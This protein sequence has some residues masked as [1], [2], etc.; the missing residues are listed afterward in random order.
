M[1]AEFDFFDGQFTGEQLDDAVSKR[2]DHANRE[3]L[4]KLGISA[5]GDLTVDG[6]AAVSPFVYCDTHYDFPVLGTE[7]KQYIATDER[8]IYRWSNSEKKYYSASVD[9]SDFKIISGGNP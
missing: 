9:L 7:N 1:A 3:F 4:D 5:S 6:A 2:H 8:V